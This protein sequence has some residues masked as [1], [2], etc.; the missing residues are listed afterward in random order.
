MIIRLHLPGIPHTIV[1]DEFSHC[2]FTG[3][4]QRFSPM[5]RSRGFE[6]FFYGVE[7]S[8]SGAD[9]Q[10]DLLT[11][12][13]W[14]ELRIA[15]Y[16]KLHPEISR[17]NAIQLLN[18]NTSFIGDLANWN[19][20]LYEVF[21]ERL[22]EAL[23]TNYRGTSS[24]IVCLPFG[25]AHEDALKGMNYVCIETGI[26]YPNSYKNY[27]IFESYAF[28]HVM[29]AREKSEQANYWFVI[30]NYY[31][32]VEFPLQLSPKKQTIGY[33]GRICQ[34]KGCQ[35]VLEVAKRFPNTDF[36]ICGQGDPTAFLQTPNIKYKNPIHGSERGEFLGSLTA[37]ITP[38]MYI[39]PFCGV[40]V[41]AQLC[42]T[43]VI[44][45][46]YGAF[47]ETI[48][49]F[50]TGV[51]CHTLADFCMGV[52]MALNNKFDRKYISE[53]AINKYD[54]YQLATRYEYVFKNVLNIHNGA[55]GW[56]ANDSYLELLSD[57]P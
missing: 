12:D 25:P 43:P 28:L 3:K 55:N 35:I 1:S 56:Y 38:S 20:P 54:M 39:E 14:S 5:M 33:F 49:P 37:L 48:E 44:A 8:E 17:E 11:K 10:I 23:K 57:N 26:G 51:L 32:V 6:V 53:R 36:I 9:K 29:M 27:R 41:E 15:S 42:G 34:I 4:V 47:T 30:P 21:N 19:T 24:D 18:N 31:N 16:V 52:Q 46:D 50:K 13:E 2:A 7:T 40:N 45:H 22:R